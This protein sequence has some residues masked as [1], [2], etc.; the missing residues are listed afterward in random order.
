VTL[1]TAGRKSMPEEAPVDFVPKK[2]AGAVTKDGEVNKHAWEFALLHEARAALRAG[3][4]IVEG[5]QRIEVPSEVLETR[6]NLIAF[7]PPT[8]LPELLMEVDTW[9]NITGEFLHLTSR[10]E[11]TEQATAELRPQLLAVLVAEATNLGLATMAHVS[12][13]PLHKLEQVYDWYFREET[14]RAAI[15]KVIGYHRS[16]P[17]TLKFG[18]GT[19]S[20]SDGI[21]FGMAA[22][23]L[24][25]RHLPR[26]FGVRLCSKRCP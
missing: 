21:R 7:F 17:L 2:W 26:Y 13:I 10:R 14:L 20:S 6:E 19:T 11:P 16:L 23:S 18:D 4:L 15:D 8:G 25:A 24:N 3:D 22:S 1:N 12:G 9:V 5:S